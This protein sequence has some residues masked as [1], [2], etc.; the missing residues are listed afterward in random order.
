MAEKLDYDELIRKEREA[1]MQK[2]NSGMFDSFARGAG[3]ATRSIAPIVAGGA[4]GAAMGAP[5]MGV[6]AIPG[7]IAG[8]TAAAFAEPLSNAAVSAYNY[9]TGNNQPTPT[10]AMEQG[11]SQL[12]LPQPETASERLASVALRSGVDAMS[13]VGAARQLFNALPQTSQVARPVM[14]TLADNPTSFTARLPFTKQGIDVGKQEMAAMLG[15]AAAQ[16]AIE[17]GAPPAVAAGAGLAAGMLP[18]VR[19]GQMLPDRG[20]EVRAAN[21]AT[22]EEAGIPVTPGQR[23]GNAFGQNVES[24]MKYLPTSGPRAARVEEE[25]MRAWTRNIMGQAGIDSDIATPEV[26]TKARQGFRTEYNTLERMTPFRGDE[27][28]FNDLAGIENS[29]VRGFNDVAPAWERMRDTV[30]NYAAGKGG[31]GIDYHRL[32]SRIS[33]EL[34]RANR[35]DAPSAGYWSQAL[36]QLQKSVADAMERSAPDANLRAAW[37]DVNRRYMVFSRIEDTMAR[38]G[39]DKLNTGFIPPQQLAAV[40]RA[41]N[42]R[43]WV[44]GGDRLTDIARAG[45]AVLPDPVPNSGTAQ[46]TFAQDLLTGASRSKWAAAGGAAGQA[47]GVLPDPIMTLGLPYFAARQWHAPNLTREQQIILGI[48]SGRGATN[49]R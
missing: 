6:G 43:Q 29:Y 34:A 28:L 31:D 1:L 47:M 32:Q 13:G 21:V 42:P 36:E 11:M 45:S 40:E 44:E 38:A 14:G 46:R 41:R 4:A 5:L 9:F 23:T 19:P 30:L 15:G 3:L 20:G 8:A 22:L 33:E 26:L 25:Q 18:N 2:A 39:A 35:S 49:T 16:G 12:G 17:A 48:Q 24:V 37:N 7:A 27:Q 10:Q